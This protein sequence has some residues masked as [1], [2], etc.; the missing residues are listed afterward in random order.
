MCHL[1]F[2]R[3]SLPPFVPVNHVNLPATLLSSNSL[4]PAKASSMDSQETQTDQETE[5]EE[6]EE[7]ETEEEA[8][9]E[10][11]EDAD[12]TVR[13]AAAGCEQSAP[14]AAAALDSSSST[15]PAEPS[16]ATSSLSSDTFQEEELTRLAC[17]YVLSSL[18]GTDVSPGR[19]PSR[20][21]GRDG[22]QLL[23]GRPNLPTGDQAV[24]VSVSHVNSPGDFF[25]HITSP[26]VAAF[27]RLVSLLQEQVTKGGRRTAGAGYSD[28][29]VDRCYAFRESSTSWHRVKVLS[30]D[31]PW[32][33]PTPQQLEQG[34]LPPPQ[35]PD[36]KAR[37]LLL[38]SGEVRLEPTDRL[39]TLHATLQS[40]PPVAIPCRVR[41]AMPATPDRS[42]PE[43][44]VREFATAVAP[45]SQ[46]IAAFY[47][48][49]TGCT[50]H[51]VPVEVFY[52]RPDN[53]EPYFYNVLRSMSANLFIYFDF[54]KPA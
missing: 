27:R 32:D 8:T 12:S 36:Q 45:G 7:V 44:A 30:L 53:P 13:D 15:S 54:H 11:Q 43:Q 18:M 20:Y 16:S 39:F 46:L 17:K 1:T 21:F 31:P 50:D 33:P 19:T 34:P 9:E 41:S 3:E 38:D 48:N 10:E 52:L 47:A 24:P 49:E 37:L 5:E 28:I 23:I 29:R 22:V 35:P 42:W 51:R 2:L 4:S 14:G 40:H 25:V 6:E 26:A